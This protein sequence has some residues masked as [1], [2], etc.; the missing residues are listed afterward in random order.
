M[1]GYLHGTLPSITYF[2]SGREFFT[3]DGF[4][5]PVGESWK[6]PKLAKTLRR[7]AAKGPEYFTKGD[8]ARAAGG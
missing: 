3:P 2:P 1:Y 5:V 8:W 7:L 4:L 6:V